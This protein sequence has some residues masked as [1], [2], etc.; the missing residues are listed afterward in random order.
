M[1]CQPVA[2][3]PQVQNYFLET[4]VYI[5]S[6][7]CIYMYISIHFKVVSFK[8]LVMETFY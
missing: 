6:F 2:L 3:T 8:I 7:I 5:Y 4:E 1:F